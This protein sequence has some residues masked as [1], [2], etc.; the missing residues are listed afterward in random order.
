LQDLEDTENQA[1]EE[2]AMQEDT[3]EVS[4]EDNSGIK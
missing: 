4:D 2:E 1:G 3:S